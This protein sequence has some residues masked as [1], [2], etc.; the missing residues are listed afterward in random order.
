METYLCGRRDYQACIHYLRGKAQALARLG[1]ELIRVGSLGSKELLALL[2]NNEPNAGVGSNNPVKRVKE[3]RIIPW[4]GRFHGPVKKENGFLY[5]FKTMSKGFSD[6]R[7]IQ[8]F[9]GYLKDEAILWF[10]GTKFRSWLELKQEFVQ[11]WCVVMT[12]TNAIV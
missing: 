2:C 3:S 10:L 1:L 6:A 8:V 11:T 9:S 4:M 12:S 7:K 5:S